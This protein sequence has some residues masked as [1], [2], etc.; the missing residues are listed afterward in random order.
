[1]ASDSHA[2]PAEKRHKEEARIRE[3]EAMNDKEVC[4]LFDTTLEDVADDADRYEQ[5]DFSDFDFSK[6]VLGRPLEKEK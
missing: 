3:G 1:M 5:G 4:K 6:T 2:G